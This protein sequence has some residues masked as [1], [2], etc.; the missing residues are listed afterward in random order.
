MPKVGGS[1]EKEVLES[2]KKGE[3]LHIAKKNE[4]DIS[5]I[6]KEVFEEKVVMGEKEEGSETVDG[7]IGQRNSETT[8]QVSSGNN[9]KPWIATFYPTGLRRMSLL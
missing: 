3:I 9:G 8:E 1:D 2:G 6:E 4:K 5:E 7:T